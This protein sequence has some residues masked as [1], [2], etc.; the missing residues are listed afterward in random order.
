VPELRIRD[1]E[2]WLAVKEIKTQ[3]FPKIFVVCSQNHGHRSLEFFRP[4]LNA[5]PLIV[6][7]GTRSRRSPDAVRNPTQKPIPKSLINSDQ[8]PYPAGVPMRNRD[9]VSDA[10]LALIATGLVLL[11]SSLLAIALR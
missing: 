2:L 5:L 7:A 3:L 1:D 4:G 10:F 9:F 11:C 6:Q 8:H